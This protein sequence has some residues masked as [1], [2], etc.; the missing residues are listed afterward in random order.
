ML[1]IV[2]ANFGTDLTKIKVFLNNNQGQQKYELR[3]LTV[4][5]T[6]I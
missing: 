1:N 4:N 3:V 2:G 6:N 5:D